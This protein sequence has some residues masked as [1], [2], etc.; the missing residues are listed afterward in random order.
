MT[1]VT[2]RMERFVANVPPVDRRRAELL[3]TFS[4]VCGV[5]LLLL[6]TA[7][8]ILGTIPLVPTLGG[9][10]VML[11]ACPFALQRGARMDVLGHVVSLG[12]FVGHCGASSYLGG[13]YSPTLA[14]IVLLPFWA[15]FIIGIRAAVLWTV[16]CCLAVAVFAVL[17]VAGTEF[18]T[19]IPESRRPISFGLAFVFT[20][21]GCLLFARAYVAYRAASQVQL[22]RAAELARMLEQLAQLEE[23]VARAAGAFSPG[24]DGLTDAMTRRTEAGHQAN[25]VAFRSVDRILAHYDRL[26]AMLKRLL[27]RHQSISDLLEA[28][29]RIGKRLEILSLS[30]S[31]EAAKV[32][33]A[34]FGLVANEIGR[35]TAA[36]NSDLAQMR[37]V[38]DAFA[39]ELLGLREINDDS[40]DLA[41]EV[42]E[43][44][45]DSDAMFG[46]L[47]HLVREVTTAA[48]ELES[49]TGR[50]LAEVRRLVD[51]AR[52]L[53]AGTA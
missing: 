32:D 44:M 11:F 17:A 22:G 25:Q 46:E 39:D 9:V 8:L 47:A 48:R 12:L 1:S 19:I 40:H 21:I 51:Q 53:D 29:K 5:F 23:S 13:V 2:T 41:S 49:E 34:A 43:R 33:E 24:S 20:Y 27:D 31:L 26:A 28:S 15:A 10:S 7:A 18:P 36:A 35:V 38:A 16:A 14:A 3:V 37:V 50:Q 6:A 52:G 42:R 45:A 4:F 30:A